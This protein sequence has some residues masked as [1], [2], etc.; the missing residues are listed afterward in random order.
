MMSIFIGATCLVHIQSTEIQ[1]L[2][3]KRMLIDRKERERKRERERFRFKLIGS[4]DVF[5]EYE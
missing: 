2:H 3:Q 1:F 5:S 4:S